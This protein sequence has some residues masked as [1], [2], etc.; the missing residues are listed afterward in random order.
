[1]QK[2]F[3]KSIELSRALFPVNIEERNGRRCIHY[4]YLF[5]K[6]KLILVAENKQST[7]SINRYNLREFDIGQKHICSEC[8]LFLKAKSKFDNLNWRKLT[9][10]NVRINLQGKI[11][12]SR[13]CASCKNLLQFVSPRSVYFTD[14][15]GDFVKYLFD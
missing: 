15:H 9:V 2:L 4:S 5:N 1:M 11:C 12:N 8:R 6:T 7:H 14:D 10:V 3:R 13:P